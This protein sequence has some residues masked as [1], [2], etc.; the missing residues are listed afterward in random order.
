[1]FF[2]VSSIS[3]I[4]FASTAFQLYPATDYPYWSMQTNRNG[5]ST[6]S[7]AFKDL[8]QQAMQ[9]I[10]SAFYFNHQDV[11]GATAENSST[12]NNHQDVYGAAAENSITFNNHQDVYSAAAE[13]NVEVH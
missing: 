4:A 11:Y 7:Q 2:I 5:S 13:N 6:H 8:Q 9:R 3:F 12:F 10:E 1:M